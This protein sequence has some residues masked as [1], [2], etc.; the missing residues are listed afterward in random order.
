M[1]MN[2][3]KAPSC[4]IKVSNV[5]PNRWKYQFV[6]FSILQLNRSMTMC[7]CSDMYYWPKPH[8][9]IFAQWHAAGNCSG[10]LPM[11]ELEKKIHISVVC[12]FNQK[13]E[14]NQ[15]GNSLHILLCHNFSF[16]FIISICLVFRCLSLFS[17]FFLPYWQHQWIHAK[18]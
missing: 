13:L 1:M 9:N 2:F 16:H 14:V 5:K 3:F 7:T 4:N 12:H 11:T 18:I 17:S 6:A 8:S 15:N 10:E